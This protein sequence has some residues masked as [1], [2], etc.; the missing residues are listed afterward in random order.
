[1]RTIVFISTLVL[2]ACSS[3][4]AKAQSNDAPTQQELNTKIAALDRDLFEA[5]NAC[6]LEKV[7]SF[8]AE[9]VE[10]Y[11]EKGGLTTTRTSVIEV[12]KKNLCSENSNRLRRE[13]IKSTFEV[14]PINTYGAVETGEH[15]FYLTQKGQKEKLDGIGKFVHIWENKDG[16]WRISRVISYGFRPPD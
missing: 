3:M 11:H 1:M 16:A 8:F 6:N 7:T 10:F 15:R 2:F 9:D 5:F 12:M 14:R 13:L 4:Q